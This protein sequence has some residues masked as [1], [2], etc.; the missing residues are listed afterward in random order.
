MEYAGGNIGSRGL[1]PTR[2]LKLGYL[3][4]LM[5]MFAFGAYFNIYLH[6]IGLTGK[7]IGLVV[8]CGPLVALV[9][10]PFWGNIADSRLGRTRTLRI[11]V[12]MSATLC[13]FFLI[14]DQV[15]ILMIVTLAIS[16]FANSVVP[17]MDSI[18]MGFVDGN[19]GGFAKIRLWGTLGGIISTVAAGIIFEKIFVGYVFI[20]YT[21]LM[22][23]C[24]VSTLYLP[25]LPPARVGEGAA[26][27]PGLLRLLNDREFRLLTL[28]AFLL[29]ATNNCHQ[30]F[31]GVYLIEHG[32]SESTIGIAWLLA[33]VSELVFW[34]SYPFL[35][36][37]DASSL[38]LAG[39]GFFSL[40][41]ALNA[42]MPAPMAIVAT[43]VLTGV[44]ISITYLAGVTLVDRFSP[45]D[46]RASGQTVFTGLT[47][48]GG[49]IMGNIVGGALY[50]IIGLRKL[51][52]GAAILAL[53]A[54]WPILRLRTTS[55]GSN[56]TQAV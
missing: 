45:A 26:S 29:Q 1:Y 20:M 46:L 25:N 51:Y 4:D 31:F 12:F 49:A 53:I 22:F 2:Y 21:V 28:A 37:F 56:T 18:T 13:P 14:S 23:L 9:S 48:G 44:S 10:Q 27:G 54:H 55:R 17:M 41:W 50:D 32:A 52:V 5:A 6:R 34:L 33:L 39:A 47:L 7:Q 24:W 15:A 43:Q 30:S 38:Y 42:L 40:R 11:L 36:R 8:A 19:E 3:F 35:Q 16:F